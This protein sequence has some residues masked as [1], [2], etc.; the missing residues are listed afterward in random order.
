MSKSK[1]GSDRANQ[2]TII[3]GV[4][5]KE[6]EGTKGRV[7]ISRRKGHNASRRSRMKGENGIKYK[8]QSG[9]KAATFS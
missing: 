5:P 7:R 6:K 2:C 8:R 3:K 9:L 4:I 1:K